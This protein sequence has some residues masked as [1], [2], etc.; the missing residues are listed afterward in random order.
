MADTALTLL[1]RALR[2]IN[3]PGRGAELQ[4]EDLTSGFETLVDLL[5]SQAVAKAFQP[6]IVRH[7]FAPTGGLVAY[8]YGPGGDLDTDPFEDPVP[9]R[10]E[11]SYIRSG[12]AIQSNEQVDE[13]DF[14]AV[15]SWAIVGAWVIANSEA[16]STGVGTLSQP[17]ALVAGRTYTIKLT[18]TVEVGDV[19]L[20]V[21]QDAVPIL[22][23]SISESGDYEFEI[24]FTGTLSELELETDN[25]LDDLA[26]QQV[27]IIELGL[28]RLEL[29]DGGTDYELKTFDQRSYNALSNKD[30]GGRPS[31]MLFSR[32]YPLATVR[33][34]G[35]WTGGDVLVL[36]VL[37]NRI[38]VATI[39]DPIRMHPDA[40]KWLRY[41]VADELAGEYG[42]ALTA[43]QVRIMD[44]AY[45]LLAAGNARANKLR[46]DRGLR[47]WR[48]FDID[49]GD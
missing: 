38:E 28:E 45:D 48:R 37:V 29:P 16:A 26:V 3:V 9:V 5:N 13:Y 49:R 46:V 1:T 32:A 40:M 15:G 11:D 27:S 41:A 36:D 7:F 6:G 10:I 34:E 4:P 12:V 47:P 31:K 20:R 19:V 43:R 33:F 24:G 30:S 18:A 8:T 14:D 2:L 23:T 25:A 42:K 35:Q 21:L 22:E 44:E 17:L 39:N